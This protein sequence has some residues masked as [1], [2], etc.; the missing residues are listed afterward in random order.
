[1][2]RVG[3]AGLQEEEE[4][5]EAVAFFG[6]GQGRALVSTIGYTVCPGESAAC[7]GIDFQ[8]SGRLRTSIFNKL[9]ESNV[10][11]GTKMKKRSGAETE[12]EIE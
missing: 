2:K 5:S 8:F 10:P 11:H 3:G 12:T 6:P 9:D 1:M 7:N 4:E